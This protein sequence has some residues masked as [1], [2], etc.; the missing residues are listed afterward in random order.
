[1]QDPAFGLVE[2]HD[3]HIGPVPKLV[4]VPLDVI[5][6]FWCVNHTIQ[7]GVICRLAEGALDPIL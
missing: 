7:L 4:Q 3:V 6:S 5:P 1:V 2:L